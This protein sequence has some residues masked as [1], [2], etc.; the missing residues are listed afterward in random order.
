[1]TSQGLNNFKDRTMSRT[2]GAPRE[3]EKRFDDQAS[4]D[5]ASF[6]ENPEVAE[7]AENGNDRAPENDYELARDNGE[8]REN[9]DQERS[10]GGSPA[11]QAENGRAEEQK[12]PRYSS[13]ERRSDRFS[14]SPY[15]NRRDSGVEQ[16]DAEDRERHGRR[17]GSRSGSPGGSR[18][19]RHSRSP[20]DRR[21]DSR[22]RGRHGDRDGGET[23][24]VYV[25]GFSRSARREDLH[26]YFSRVGGE[27][28]D[29]HV[30][31]KF[32][33]V[34]YKQP[35]DAAEAVRQLDRTDF[36]GYKLT[37]QLSRKS[38]LISHNQ[39]FERQFQS[40]I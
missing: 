31:S 10:R 14:Q 8:P 29:V 32:A 25:T 27:I 15:N 12:S 19:A 11:R 3:G 20:R 40:R 9:A 39:V 7:R 26:N 17:R 2:N 6:N 13:A 1:M 30:K 5:R 22:D 34:E 37:V 16:G 35:A 38:N 33:F 24:S 21:A 36:D 4:G 28:R 23:C 18:G